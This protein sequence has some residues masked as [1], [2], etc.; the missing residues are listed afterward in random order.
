MSYNLANKI[1]IKCTKKIHAFSI[2][3]VA[4]NEF[5][6]EIYMELIGNDPYIN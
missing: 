2:T 3:L 6:A 5:L 4:R 1:F